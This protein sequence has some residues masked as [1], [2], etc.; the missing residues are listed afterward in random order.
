[1]NAAPEVIRDRLPVWRAFSEFFLDTELDDEAIARIAGVLALSPYDDE[2]L[3]NILSAERALAIAN[4]IAHADVW[5]L[6]PDD[7]RTLRAYADKVDE[8]QGKG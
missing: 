4:I 7:A 1:M 8:L 6:F 3:W 5:W 2:E